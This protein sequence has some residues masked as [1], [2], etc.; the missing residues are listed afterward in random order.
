MLFLAFPWMA[1]TWYLP[2]PAL[3]T[4]VIKDINGIVLQVGDKVTLEAVI[5]NIF[6]TDLLNG[7]IVVR[8]IHPQPSTNTTQITSLA[9]IK[10]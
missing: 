10:L 6:A 2:P 3:P 1:G 8:F 4:P 5:E 7:Y 9:A